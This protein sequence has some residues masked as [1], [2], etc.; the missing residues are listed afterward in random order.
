MIPVNEPLLG[1][2]ELEYATECIR[3]GWISSAGGFIERFETGWA[4]YCGMHYGVAVSNGTVALQ[5][6]STAWTCSRATR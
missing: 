4:A 1:G 3:T 5:V 2:R 6:A